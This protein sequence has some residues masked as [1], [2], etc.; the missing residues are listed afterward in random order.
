MSVTR[1][2]FLKILGATAAAA[3]V[4][5]PVLTTPAAS[6]GAPL[7]VPAERL[8]FGVPREIATARSLDTQE[9]KDLWQQ[10]VN[11]FDEA[12]SRA[13]MGD[14]VPMTLVQDEFLLEWGGRLAAGSTVMVDP[15]TAYRWIAG[16]VGVAAAGAPMELRN[17]S[18]RVQGE[19]Q[20][21]RD[22]RAESWPFP[23]HDDDEHELSLNFGRGRVADDEIQA[24]FRKHIARNSRRDGE[25]GRWFDRV[26]EAGSDREYA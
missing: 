20:R 19:R 6:A 10:H 17:E 9:V 16:G 4:A 1:R 2:S 18:V 26:P 21:E 11:R 24:L 15:V 22:K 12:R 8:D 25:A 5:H 23:E 13:I 14:S 3:A 7:F